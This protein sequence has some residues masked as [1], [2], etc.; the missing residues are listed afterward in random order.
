MNKSI[1]CNIENNPKR[2]AQ[3]F[4]HFSR[5]FAVQSDL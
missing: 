4:D 1:Q 3:T 5:Q 2:D